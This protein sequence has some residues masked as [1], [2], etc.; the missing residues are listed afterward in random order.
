MDEYQLYLSDLIS[1]YKTKT[2]KYSGKKRLY[3][4]GVINGLQSALDSY[5]EIKKIESKEEQFAIVIPDNIIEN[6]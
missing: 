2:F 3:Y 5:R 1:I 6:L 4:D